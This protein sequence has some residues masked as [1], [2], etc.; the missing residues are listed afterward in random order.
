MTDKE[1]TASDNCPENLQGNGEQY[2][3]FFTYSCY[4]KKSHKSFVSSED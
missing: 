2:L 1:K 3:I 4:T